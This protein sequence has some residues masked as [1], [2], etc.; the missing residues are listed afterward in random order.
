[1]STSW[2][3]ALVGLAWAVHLGDWLLAVL[4]RRGRVAHRGEWLREIVVRLAMAALVVLALVRPG[5]VP[6][7]LLATIA[8]ALVWGGTMLAIAG[9]RRL[10]GAWGI[11]VRPHADMVTTGIHSLVRHPIYIG[12]SAV[13]VGQYIALA[14]LPSL[15]L[16][17]GALVVVPLK[18]VREG[19]LLRRSAV[20]ANRLGKT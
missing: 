4:R 11:G 18:I 3:V 14:N 5:R 20:D 2:T 8:L 19:V 16:L 12:T 1:M 10:A 7:P 17:I 9:R 6:A 15:L 13:L